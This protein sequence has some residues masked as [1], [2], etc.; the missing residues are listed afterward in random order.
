M[1]DSTANITNTEIA[2]ELGRLPS[3]YWQ[4]ENSLCGKV[5]P[6]PLRWVEGAN[7]TFACPYCKSVT[8]E[9]KSD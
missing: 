6:N 4:C 8:I 2:K 1:N 5:V 9:T 7:T 3:K